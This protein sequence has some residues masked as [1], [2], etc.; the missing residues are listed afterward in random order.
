M[1][2]IL[3]FSLLIA[4]AMLP[5]ARA[6]TSAI[7]T[8]PPHDASFPATSDAFQIPTHGKLVNALAYLAAGH[9]PHPTV[10]LLHGF[11]G[12]E[13]NLDLAQAI[14]RA[15]WNVLY[16]NY[17][18]AWGSPGDFSFAH[19]I[20]DAEAALVWL[21]QPSNADRLRTDPARLVL[22]GH[23]MGGFVALETAARDPAVKAVITISAAD[24]SEALARDVPQSDKERWLSVT[25]ARLEAEGLAPLAGTSA[26]TLAAELA[27]NAERW[28]FAA[29]APGLVHHSVLA[30]TS[31]DGL[32]VEVAGLITRL[33]ETGNTQA[34][35]IHIATDHAYSD[36]R[37]ALTEAVLAELDRL[38]QQP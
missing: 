22:V 3:A 24:M 19:C 8:D 2:H 1:K 7:T 30:I 10:V 33:R 14:R 29:L 5:A 4:L 9:G 31:D 20:E 11:P 15:G 36:R 26:K 21:R 16:F 28:R 27:A 13:R 23:S 17:R 35:E 34:R 32:T 12:N 18:G 25:A 6:E 38:G 37:I